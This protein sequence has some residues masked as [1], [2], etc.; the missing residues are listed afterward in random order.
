M[1]QNFKNYS[2]KKSNFKEQKF[3]LDNKHKRVVKEFSKEKK[4]IPKLERKIKQL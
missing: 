3:T 4:K 2:A 1:S